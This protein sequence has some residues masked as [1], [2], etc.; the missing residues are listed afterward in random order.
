MRVAA[1]YWS[2]VVHA[3]VFDV[4]HP[5]SSEATAIFVNILATYYLPLPTLFHSFNSFA[6]SGMLYIMTN[7]S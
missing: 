3:A 6:H 2:F 7:N 4:E 1:C 5:L